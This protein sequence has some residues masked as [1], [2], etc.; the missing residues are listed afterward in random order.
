MTLDPATLHDA[1]FSD[2]PVKGLGRLGP[3]RYAAW[4]LGLAWQGFFAAPDLFPSGPVASLSLAIPGVFGRGWRLG[5]DLDI[6]G[7][8]A[9]LV[10]PGL[11]S[12]PYQTVELGGGLS[13]EREVDLGPVVLSAGGRLAYLY[14]ARH[15]DAATGLPAQFFATFTPGVT[16]GASLRLGAG[17]SL[18][19][20]GRVHYLYYNVDGDRSLGYAELGAQ[21]VYQKEPR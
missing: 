17:F 11:A 8:S 5:V 15:F 13:V 3:P 16:A 19:L 20:S 1:P 18:A 12:V 4:K 9:T 2:D 21:I 10:A 6:G 7:T 14:L